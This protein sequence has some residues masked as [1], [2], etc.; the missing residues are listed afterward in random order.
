MVAFYE[1]MEDFEASLSREPKFLF[2][3]L[4]VATNPISIFQF[5]PRAD[6]VRNDQTADLA[7]FALEE[8]LGRKA[9]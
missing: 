6:A 2:A 4:P 8:I 3:L 1:T 5:Y 7:F 9:I